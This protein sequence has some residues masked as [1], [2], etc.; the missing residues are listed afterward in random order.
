SFLAPN[1][2]PFYVSP[3]DKPEAYG[4]NAKFFKYDPK[5]AK[6]LL[7]AA[8]G[9]DTLKFKLYANV[10]AYG[11][12]FQQRWEAFASTIQESGF[13]AE[14]TYVDYAT[15]Y[16]QSIYLGKI[17]EGCAVG[18][19]IAVARDPDDMLMR[20]YWSKS[21][22]HNWG[23]TPIPEMADL[24]AAFE[25]QRTILDTNERLKFV[26]DLQAT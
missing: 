11:A 25:K 4:D 2:A 24:D 15:V 21:A 16:T 9:S 12:A 14:L 6:Q 13:Q 3:R 8:T 22:R 7:Q 5:S 18:P 19:L 17:P 10:N 26:Q 20:C 23:G 1:V